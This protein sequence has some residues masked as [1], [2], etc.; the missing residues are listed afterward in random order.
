[1]TMSAIQ[2]V[3]S[4]ALAAIRKAI[5]WLR[6]ESTTTQAHVSSIRRQRRGSATELYNCGRRIARFND[7]DVVQVFARDPNDPAPEMLATVGYIYDHPSKREVVIIRSTVW[8]GLGFTPAG[9]EKLAKAPFAM[10]VRYDDVAVIVPLV[11]KRRRVT[12]K[13]RRGSRTASREA[14]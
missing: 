9:I 8:P 7:G 3:A 5:H 4:K 14:A 6:P 13:R 12:R 10:T 11:W 2:H 1:M